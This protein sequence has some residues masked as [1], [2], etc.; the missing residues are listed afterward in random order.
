MPLKLLIF[1]GTNRKDSY[2]QHVAKF[3]LEI[4][5]TYTDFE[6]TFITPQS[7]GVQVAE[8]ANGDAYPEFRQMVI[9]ADAYLIVAPE[10]NH[11]YSG[12]LK[13]LLDL[14]IKEY[15]HKP[16]GIVGVSNGAIGGA[17]MIEALSNVVRALGMVH[18][19]KDVTVTNVEDE[20]EDGHIV[21][22]AKWEKRIRRTIDELLWMAKV[23][24]TGRSQI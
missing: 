15:I 20:V 16:V 2:T 23:L 1:Q 22:P 21:D 11:G 4:A 10:Y 12:S 18:T 19:W 6:I 8:E 14:T 9:D 17:R 3:V 5:K 7:V 13:M 24:K